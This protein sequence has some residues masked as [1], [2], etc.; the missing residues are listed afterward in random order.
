MSMNVMLVV[1]PAP[2]IPASAREDRPVAR[3]PPMAATVEMRCPESCIASCSICLQKELNAIMEQSC[4][5]SNLSSRKRL[6][7]IAS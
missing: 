7:V 1:L 6:S 2:N 4:V 3:H 5:T